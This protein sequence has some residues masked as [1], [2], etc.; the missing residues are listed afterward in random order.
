MKAVY[1]ISVSEVLAKVILIYRLISGCFQYQESFII[2]SGN[3][4]SCTL[5]K[6]I[7]SIFT[8]TFTAENSC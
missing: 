5:T 7:F 8:V 4:G 2:T 6:K 1:R 3:S